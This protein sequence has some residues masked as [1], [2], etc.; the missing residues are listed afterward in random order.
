MAFKN[1]RAMVFSKLGRVGGSLCLGPKYLNFILRVAPARVYLPKK[2]VGG[3][4]T[5]PNKGRSPW[6]IGNRV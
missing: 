1:T 5:S 3:D 2:L 6:M 4:L